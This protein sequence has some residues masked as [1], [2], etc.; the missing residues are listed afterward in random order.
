MKTKDEILKQQ[1]EGLFKTHFKPLSYFAFKYVND[2]DSAKEIVHN[3]FL[4]IW[5]SRDNFDWAK[6]AKSYLFTSVYNRSLNFIRDRKKNLSYEN[7]GALENLSA[8]PSYSTNIEVSELEDKIKS[9]I[10]RLPVK[11]RQIFHL[12]RFENK[13]YSEIAE[14]LGI[15]VKTVET[16]MSKALLILRRELKEYLMILIIIFMNLKN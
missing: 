9:A 7:S 2:L 10:N 3:V 5:E 11:C 16:Q 12:S 1:L 8:D 14:T 6:P 15:S 13:K 4:K